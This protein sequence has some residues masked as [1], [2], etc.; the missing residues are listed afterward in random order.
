MRF[1]RVTRLA[2]TPRLHLPVPV[3]Q[4]IITDRHTGIP[5]GFIPKIR[6][7]VLDRFGDNS[8]QGKFYGAC[9]PIT[10]IV[11]LNQTKVYS[12]GPQL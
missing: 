8:Y 10:T 4:T 11:K 2:V 9:K 3:T 6:E 1:D 12:D 7:T 5:N